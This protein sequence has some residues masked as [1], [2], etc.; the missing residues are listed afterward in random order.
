MVVCYIVKEC[1][2]VII[3]RLQNMFIDL[4]NSRK[5]GLEISR[6]FEQ[7]WT[8]SHALSAIDGKHLRIA[9]PN[10]GGSYFCNYKHTYSI[11]LLAIAGPEYEY[12]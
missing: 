3:D 4:P 2:S 11:I 9:K 12:L 10:N 7:R 1:C 6:K 8:Y 5:K